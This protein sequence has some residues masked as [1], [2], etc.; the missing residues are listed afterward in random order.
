[1]KELKTIY[2]T[3]DE[4]QRDCAVMKQKRKERKYNEDNL[5]EQMDK[6]DLIEQKELLQNNEKINSKKNI[7]LTLT[8][9]RTFPNISEVV[10]KNWYILQINPKFRNVFVNK[11]TI[12][13]KRNKYIQDLIGGHLLKDG[14]VDKKKIQKRQG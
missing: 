12:V 7:L 6:V 10:T 13:F 5:N 2:S 1:M 9:S 8:Y 3:E 14:K 11:P 4:Y